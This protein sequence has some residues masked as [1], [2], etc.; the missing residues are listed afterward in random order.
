MDINATDSTG[1]TA[2][3]ELMKRKDIPPK[4]LEKF[5]EKGADVNMDDK[6]SQR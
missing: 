3:H 4:F 2:L 1:E 5:V 6:D